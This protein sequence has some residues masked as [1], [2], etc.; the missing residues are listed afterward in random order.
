MTE[1]EAFVCMAPGCETLFYAQKSEML[2][3]RDKAMSAK[4]YIWHPE[5][6]KC[7]CIYMNHVENPRPDGN[8]A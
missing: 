3:A 5:C 2:L 7:G 6:P 1:Q 4:G 8:A